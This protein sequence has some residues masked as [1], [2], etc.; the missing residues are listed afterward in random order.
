[1]KLLILYTGGTIGMVAQRDGSLVPFHA[2]ALRA[3]VPDLTRLQAE[4]DCR[5]LGQPKDSSDMGPDDWVAM[6][7]ALW[8]ARDEFDGFVVLHGTD[9]MAYSA[10]A[11]S[12]MLGGTFGKPVVLTGSQ[13]PLGVLRSDGRDNLLTSLEIALLRGGDGQAQ[14]REVAVFFENRLFRGNRVYKHSALQ[15]DAFHSPNYPELG[16]S[17]VE[18]VL[19]RKRLWTPDLAQARRRDLNPNVAVATLS[20][21]MT[22]KALRAMLLGSGAQGVVIQT[23]GSGNAPAWPWL[24]GLLCEAHEAG[25]SL[26]HVSQCR[27]A[28]PVASNYASGKVIQDAGVWES[29]GMILEAAV[30]KMM[31]VLALPSAQRAAAWTA[32]WAGERD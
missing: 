10:S 5:S 7:D 13:V 28:A 12:F 21:G 8:A 6:A 24:G 3:N 16:R 15:F 29:G 18:L 30:V 1:V 17:G 4:V 25:V 11:L 20:P 14:L 27:A 23:L 32:S 31:L 2:D 22:E 9:T 19:H 26:A